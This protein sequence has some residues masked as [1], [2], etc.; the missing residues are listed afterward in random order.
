MPLSLNVARGTARSD[1]DGWPR[2]R[3]TSRRSLCS[4]R[5]EVPR[6]GGPTGRDT[7]AD[8][9]PPWPCTGRTTTT[10]PS[11]T[12]PPTDRSVRTGSPQPTTSGDSR[13]PGGRAVPSCPPTQRGSTVPTWN[14][15]LTQAAGSPQPTRGS[16]ATERPRS[17]AAP[18]PRAGQGRAV[19]SRA[20]RPSPRVHGIGHGR[21]ARHQTQSAP[22]ARSEPPGI[23]KQP[24]A[25]DRDRETVSL[26]REVRIPARD[27]SGNEGQRPLEEV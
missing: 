2:S 13:R 16:S 1:Q 15:L 21:S 14:H 19:R 7:S 8:T 9:T 10:P 26:L 6:S 23:V 20:H 25:A 24:R 12:L 5:R 4:L 3:T 22:V 11:R 17:R 18:P 27:T